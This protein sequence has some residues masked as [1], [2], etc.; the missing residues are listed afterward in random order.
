MS[1]FTFDPS[2]LVLYRNGEKVVLPYKAR[3]LLALLVADLNSLVSHER[4]F[5]G[6]WPDGFVHEGNLTQT[7]YLLRKCLAGDSRLSIENVPGRGYRLRVNENGQRVTP[8]RRSSIHIAGFGMAAIVALLCIGIWTG[9]RPTAI[10]TLPLGARNDFDV[11]MYHFDRFVNLR[12]ART[13]FEL[14][15]KDAPSAPEGYAGVALTDAI[16]AY[17]SSE[18]A[19]Y[20]A[21]GRSAVARANGLGASALAHTASAMLEVACERSLPRARRELDAALALDPSNAPALTLR[22][23]VSLWGSR[24]SEAIA[25]AKKAATN[26]PT[27]PEAMLALGIAEYYARDLRDSARTFER[28]LE[29]MPDRSVA[30]DYLERSFE[31][32]GELSAADLILR[33]A[34]PESGNA[35]WVWAARARLLARRGERDKS[36]AVLQWRAS[37]SDPESLAAAYAAINDDDAAIRDLEIAEARHSLNTQIAWLNDFRF[38]SLR[39]KFPGLSAAFVTWRTW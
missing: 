18:K 27:S 25:F 1:S 31:G 23:R 39:R 14:T 32:L 4:I 10:R 24:P 8:P 37:T 16:D 34:E 3:E 33:R 36:L 22:A 9:L 11:A 17:D 38:A 26:D 30:L 20:C 2:T 7:I 19:R 15:A 28:L 29:L 35:H 5:G 12:L 21:H 6:L 13:Y